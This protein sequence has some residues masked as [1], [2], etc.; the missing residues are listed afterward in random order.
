MKV[1]VIIP[2]YNHASFLSQRLESIFNQT[3][4]D[5]E[6]ILLDDCSTDNSCVVLDA[7]R[8]NPHVSHVVYNKTNGGSPFRQWKNGIEL[9]KGEWVWIAESDD[10]AELSFLQELVDE[11]SKQ[12][13]VVLAF[14]NSFHD[15]AN[16]RVKGYPIYD[17]PTLCNGIGFV[18]NHMLYDQ[19]IYNASSVLFRRDVAA[20][21]PLDY[22]Y[23]RV[24]GDKLFWIL[25]CEQGNVF[26]TPQCLNHFRRHDNEVSAKETV[27]GRVF[28]EE[29]RIF[30]SIKGRKYI[31]IEDRENIVDYYLS[32]IQ[33]QYAQDSEE[34]KT[35][36]TM[37]LNEKEN[38][39]A[40]FTHKFLKRILHKLKSI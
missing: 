14:C 39:A 13:N 10:W 24:A 30:Q 2:N 36:S 9:A 20:S 37:W 4:Q 18:R 11:L 5:F 21:F 15:Y 38:K 27:S 28:E 29:L 25:T 7:Y 22:T 33:A 34:Y 8:S 32:A 6:V 26:Y 16:K 31:S 1:S 35:L 23:Y 19:A 12:S 3:F 17:R 40:L